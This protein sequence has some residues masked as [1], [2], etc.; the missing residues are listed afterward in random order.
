MVLVAC[1]PRDDQGD[2]DSG[3]S[4]TWG[5]T[6][7]ARVVT[8]ASPVCLDPVARE[9]GQ[10]S[11]LEIGADWPVTPDHN[12]A[13][14]NLRFGG[15]GVTVADFDGDGVDDILVPRDGFKSH[16]LR[17]VGDGTFEERSNEWLGDQALLPHFMG[18]SAA[19]IDGDGDMDIIAYGLL[20][21]A[22]LMFNDGTGVLQWDDRPEWTTGTTGYGCGGSASFA[23]YDRDGDLDLFF[24]RLG[25]ED[26]IGDGSLFFCD[27]HL[28][29]WDGAGYSMQS[30]QVTAEVQSIRSM[31]AGWDDFDGDGWLD[32]YVVSDAPPMPNALMINDQNGGF[33]PR[34]EAGLDF[35]VAGMGLALGDLNG[36]EYPDLMVPGIREMPTL[37]SLPQYGNVWAESSNSLGLKMSAEDGQ[38]VGWGGEIC[39]MD[40]DGLADMIQTFG[41]FPGSDSSRAQPDEIYLNKGDTFER[42]GA[43]WGFGDP[44][45]NRGFAVADLNDDGWLDIIKRELGGRVFVDISACGDAAWLEVRLRDEGAHNG[46]GIGARLRITAGGQTWTR[47]IYAGSTS[48][49]SSGPAEAHFGLGDL[50]VIDRLE[51]EWP[52]GG[53]TS[54]GPMST[55]QIIE[56][57]RETPGSASR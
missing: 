56:V 50:D 21:D 27:S 23:D 36:D 22:V 32:L 28:L 19:D 35:V 44:E 3:S 31:V 39:D 18:S 7:D 10:L 51:V 42:V 54:Y 30:H 57:Y 40:N 5:L 17:G 1:G 52:D 34:P 53:A 45:V 12:Q 16:M 48:F 13:S 38:A 47:R 4:S 55:R 26:H 14:W 41:D 25:G 11:R 29:R 2:R 8:V 24:G 20:E 49:A 9:S 6:D 37:L 43:S 33:V 46:H 15:R